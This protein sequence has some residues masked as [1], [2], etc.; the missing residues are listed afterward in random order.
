M[1]AP[2]GT[3]RPGGNA[4]GIGRTRRSDGIEHTYCVGSHES[5]QLGSSLRSVAQVP[6]GARRRAWRRHALG[7]SPCRARGARHIDGS[8]RSVGPARQPAR[9]VGPESITAWQSGRA[10]RRE[11]VATTRRQVVSSRHGMVSVCCSP[12]TVPSW[13]LR[14]FSSLIP[15]LQLSSSS[16]LLPLSF[17]GFFS[18][19]AIS[20]ILLATT[21]TRWMSIGGISSLWPR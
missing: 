19:R 8:P 10:A 1:P 18:V 13:P 7:V 17:F 6:A 12:P 3:W 2:T 5:G 15:E 11:I 14:P 21:R 20:S 9:K 16:S 4:A